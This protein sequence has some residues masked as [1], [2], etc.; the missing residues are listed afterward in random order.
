M[1]DSGRDTVERLLAEREVLLV[2]GPG[3][4][5]KTT[6]AASLAVRAASTGRRVLA[7]TVDPARR[8]A[9][10][11]GLDGDGRVDLPGGGTLESIMVD[12]RDGWDDL[13]RRLSPDEASAEALIADPL[14]R[15]LTDRFARSHDYLALEAVY[16]RHLSG[17]Y[18]LIVVDTPPARHALDVIDAP[19]RMREFFASRLARLLTSPGRSRLAALASR[20]FDLVADVVL[21]ARFLRDITTFFDLFIALE[22]EFVR[23]AGGV[24]RLLRSDRTAFIAVTTP[25]PNPMRE[26][27]EFAT[28]LAARRHTLDLVVANRAPMPVAVDELIDGLDKLDAQR[29]ES[30]RVVADRLARSADTRRTR[31]TGLA[32][33]TPVLEVPESSIEPVTVDALAELSGTWR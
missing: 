7:I 24:E 29:R 4:V 8:L 30:I 20:G 26:T 22:P 6:T 5:G 11:L 1:S 12:T 9:D 21:G 18:D 32:L 19:D 16:E 14:Y 13:V 17:D 2:C 27:R 23:R 15:N 31:L 28:E 33:D 3:G 10:A 25:E